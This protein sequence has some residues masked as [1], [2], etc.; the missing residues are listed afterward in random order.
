MDSNII[1]FTG[2][3][4]LIII[5]IIVL[6]SLYATY[7]NP[8]VPP[9]S[10]HN[11]LGNWI[12]IQTSLGILP[13]YYFTSQLYNTEGNYLGIFDQALVL[14]PYNNVWEFD[15]R[16]L[17]TIQ[18]GA[19]YYVGMN[20]QNQAVSAGFP[21]TEWLFDGFNFYQASNMSNFIDSSTLQIAIITN[22]KLYY[23][24]GSNFFRA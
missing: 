17:S 13:S 23:P 1:I 24:L 12:S 20:N 19:R 22:P 15:G 10:G 2:F 18:D 4:I 14:G 9:S 8:K 16:Y 21:M 7:R 5:I 6:F 3:I 11:T